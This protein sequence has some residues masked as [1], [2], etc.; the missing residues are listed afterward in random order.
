[1]DIRERLGLLAKIAGAA[2][3]VVSVYLNTRWAD[4]HQR[5][6]VRVFLKNAIRGARAAG[7]RPEFRE[8]LDWIER[9]GALLVQQAKFPEAHGVALFACH[10]LGLR[11]VLPV[12]VPFGD[13]FLVADRPFL[14][15]LAEV[16]E[17]AP[18]ALLVFVDGVS[19]RLI[20]LNPDG[21][22]EE[23]TLRH[24]VEGRHRRGGWA[25]MAQSRYQRHIEAHRG[26]H[27]EAVAAALAQM[28][29]ERGIEH[30]VLAGETRALAVFAKHLPPRLAARVVGSVPAARY[31][32]ASVLVERAAELLAALDRRQETV[33]V[34][35]TLI[36]AAKGGRAVAGLDETLD[37]VGRG[38]V[39][40]LYLSKGFDQQGRACV[41]CGALQNG[42]GSG[43]RA[44]GAPTRETQLGEAIV[45]RVIAAG[46]AVEVVEAHP[47]LARVGGI[48]A[49]LRYAM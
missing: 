49:R 20:P 40:H 25:L 32:S 42:E 36:E 4:E 34:E 39:H 15:P 12:R 5:E 30:I 38:A 44:C 6:R 35:S 29:D 3:P 41:A 37:A 31:E 22:G 19:A 9:E 2:T 13:A 47:G 28:V 23:V 14:T 18:P 16:A 7:G 10:A 46:G 26:Q 1:M 43:C 27:F 17:E 21:R 24:E 11:E 48:A 45:D 8:D 33:A